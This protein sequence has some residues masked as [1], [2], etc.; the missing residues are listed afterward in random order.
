MSLTTSLCSLALLLVP[1]AAFSQQ[2]TI[3]TAKDKELKR[4]AHRLRITPDR[5]RHARRALDDATTLVTRI[6]PIPVPQVS[7]IA[8]SWL[9]LHRTAAP[10][11]IEQLFGELKRAAAEAADE[12]AYRQQTQS[13]QILLA[14]LSEFNA[15]R[16]AALA[17]TWPD[18]PKRL[19]ES[20]AKLRSTFETEFTKQSVRQI[21]MRNPEQIAS[22]L[23]EYEHSGTLDPI[24]MSRVAMHLSQTGRREDAIRLLDK[25][26]GGMDQAARDPRLFSDYMN[27]IPMFPMVDSERAV[28]AVAGL[29]RV[30]KELGTMPGGMTLQTQGGRRADLTGAE[31]AVVRMLQNNRMLN[32]EQALRIITTAPELKAKLDSIGG[33]DVLYGPTPARPVPPPEAR[34]A[35][36]ATGN[37]YG[38]A[39][40]PFENVQLTAKLRTLAGQDPEAVKKQVT[41]DFQPEQFQQLLRTAQQLGYQNDDLATTALETARTLLARIEP[42]QRRAQLMNFMVRVWAEV[43]GEIIPAVYREGFV[44]VDDLRHPPAP[45]SGQAAP[46]DAAAWASAADGLE[47]A[48]LT[49]YARDDFDGALKYINGMSD[50][51]AKVRTLLEIVQRFL[52]PF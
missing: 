49:E 12:A 36:G 52:S 46:V 13:G 1:T 25:A 9:R 43:D 41:T 47:Q 15:D 11:R 28:A 31:V 5:L 44:L 21:G 14:S 39:P 45:A 27:L 10:Q 7:Q 4:S 29:I 20:V 26:I 40:S 51:A 24:V 18:P 16:A 22:R 34:A 23:E 6:D 17:R 35:M 50:N 2:L 37:P 30:S 19:G 33:M 42:I 32:P 38:V 8:T 3:V 48:L